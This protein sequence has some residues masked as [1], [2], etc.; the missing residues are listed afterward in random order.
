M[1]ID[2]FSITDRAGD[3]MFAT[4]ELKGLTLS[5]I[6]IGILFVLS[7]LFSR[8]GMK[9]EY[10]RKFLHIAISHW[11]LIATHFFT[12]EWVAVIPPLTFIFANVLAR[13]YKL[14]E[15]M[16]RK[17]DNNQGLIYY[18][19]SM[20]IL[21]LF[22]FGLIRE[23]YIGAIGIFILGYGDGVAAIVGTRWG[24]RKIY[25]NKTLEGSLAMLLTTFIVTFA[26]LSM[27]HDQFKWFA[28]IM[29][30]VIA[31]FLE[32][33]SPRGHDNLFIPLFSS[34]FYYFVFYL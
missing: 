4:S 6:F 20:A 15:A 30:S 27:A 3:F 7:K 10:N 24:K 17:P 12:R 22:S 13:D 5:Y 29:V 11:W 23:P 32:I 34:L 8:I 21:V 33:F 25:R 19:L 26:I 1:T 31:T 16:E 14:L 2:Y 9:Q 28:A 18:P